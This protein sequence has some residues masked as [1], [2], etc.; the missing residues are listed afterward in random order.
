MHVTGISSGHVA[1][2]AVGDTASVTKPNSITVNVTANDYSTS[3]DTFCITSVS[4]TTYFSIAS[5]TDI[6]FNSTNATAPGVDSTWYVICNIHQPTLCDSALLIV[7]VDKAH[8]AP[9]AVNVYDTTTQPSPITFNIT[10]QDSSA[11][12]DSFCVTSIYPP[13]GFT[14]VN[15]NDVT[16]TPDS[17]FTGNDTVHY[18]ICNTGQPALCDTAEVIVTVEPHSVPCQLTDSIKVICG[19][20]IGSGHDFSCGFVITST[21]EFSSPVDSFSWSLT[22]PSL[23]TVFHNLDTLILA[24]PDYGGMS[25]VIIQIQHQYLLCLSAY[26][27]NC[28]T[29]TFCD[30]VA[31]WEEGINDLT[32][33]NI[34]I[35]PNP[36]NN[37]LT[38]DMLHNTDDITADYTAIQI[39]NAIGQQVLSKPRDNQ[40]KL[41]N[42][43]VTDLPEGMYLATIVDSKG[44][45]RTLGKFTVVR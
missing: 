36:A 7:T 14:I 21:T 31:V 17:S 33:S 43:P 30:T 39:Y 45:R 19:G 18:V 3:G 8:I 25:N 28:G 38:V 1:P 4:N 15:C 6:T 20:Q 10:A 2:V 12:G 34:S 29:A 13:A 11:S 32:L 9:V 22:G 26:S 40:Y 5:C 41:V 27:S 44:V 24:G 35:Y 42:I 16:Y 37:V 23:D